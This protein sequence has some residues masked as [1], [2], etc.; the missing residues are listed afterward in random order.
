MTDG[1]KHVLKDENDL[2]VDGETEDYSNWDISYEEVPTSNALGS[3]SNV[4][5]ETHYSKTK[6]ADRVSTERQNRNDNKHNNNQDGSEDSTVLHSR[7]LTNPAGNNI[8][9]RRI[10]KI[11]P[12][13]PDW[14]KVVGTKEQFYVYS[15]YHN[16]LFE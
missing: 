13:Q 6:L 16:S 1:N 2:V 15:A 11:N 4:N 5:S 14:Q 8:S 10:R 3:T 12:I 7:T 9:S